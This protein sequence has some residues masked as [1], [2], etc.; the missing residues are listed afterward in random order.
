MYALALPI[1]AD[2]TAFRA[3][4][5]RALAAGLSPQQ[6]VFVGEEEASLL[7]PL[8]EAEVEPSA[9]T[10]PRAY[11]DLVRDA[12]CH[13]A[14]DRF[15]LLYDVLWRTTHGERQLIT[16]ATDPAVAQLRAYAHAIRRDIHKMHA[17]LRFRARE[18]DG[19]TLYT[20]WFEPQHFILKQAIPFFVDRFASMDWLI[21][22]PMGTALWR[23]K[24]LV[25][26]PPV[27]KP[28]AVD[29]SV[30]D[31]LWLTYYRT[32]FNPARVRL[33]AMRA[34]MPKH[35]WGNMPETALIPHM[36]ATADARVAD[37]HERTADRPQLFAEKIASRGRPQADAPQ[38]P[39]AQLRA[40]ARG[41][42]RCPLH[43]PA[44]QTVFGDGPEDASLVFVGEQPGDQE[45]L[46]GAPFI[47]PAGQLFDRALADAG[48]ERGGVYV[49]NAV[50]HFKYE[51]RGKRRIHKR[52]NV[53]EVRHCKWWLDRELA[54]IKP[55]LI[56]AMGA[57]AAQSLGGRAV[58]VLRER[59][60]AAFE[61]RA[62]FITVHPSFLLRLPDADAQREEYAKF[63]TDLRSIRNM[64][65][66]APLAP[67]EENSDGGEAQSKVLAGG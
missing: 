36:V 4:A 5:R 63:V 66:G 46:A 56:V 29:D 33:N 17:F 6:V 41:C 45:D 48:I 57:T 18:L 23:E 37:M 28:D 42:Q 9:I 54:T 64:L 30:L 19:A 40:E 62:G 20:A 10:A 21:A 11:V 39:I 60:P 59:G 12:I 7:P 24:T 3:A 47:G 35:Y 34:E 44:T 13:R 53:G 55:R 67:E 14:A 65:A 43:G 25:Y 2:E 32:T 38:T 61:G 16:R 15:S 22:T 31:D 51:P 49:T 52:P 50:K 27:S 26:G 1:C 8:A 58:S